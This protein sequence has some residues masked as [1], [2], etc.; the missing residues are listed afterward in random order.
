[1]KWLFRKRAS[2]ASVN[3][4]P[5]EQVLLQWAAGTPWTIRDAF[6]GTQ[7]LGSTGSGKTSASL[8]TIV[9]S[10]LRSGFGG[11]FF[12]VK[13]EDRATYERWIE[14][15][16]RRDDLLVFSPTGG[17]RYNFM[18]AELEQT[19][20]VAA[21]AENLTALVMTAAEIGD[22][23]RGSAGGGGENATYFIQNSHKYCRNAV[24]VLR[25]SGNPITP[26]NLL[27]VVMSTP[28]TVDEL[29]SPSWQ[30]SSFCFQCLRRAE[31]A[32]MRESERADLGMAMD[33]FC[34]ELPN[35]NPRT[36][37]SIETTL[38]A[39]LDALGRGLVRDMVSA[40]SSNFSASML[41][42]GAIVIADFPVL[43]YRD[44]GRLIQVMLK[45]SLQRAHSRRDVGANPRPCFMVCDEYQYLAVAEDQPF[46]TIARAFGIAV[47]N[48]TQSI[49]T[50]M[51]ALGPQSEVK[52]NALLGNL[53]T[54]IFHQQTDTRTI[55]YIQE[56][57]G[58]SRQLMVNGNSTRGGDWL[59][60]LFGNN[61][62]GS[63][64]FSE[65]YEF[66]LQARDLNGLAKGGPPHWTAEAI[67]Y[68]GG[69]RFPN[70]RTWMPVTFRQD[71]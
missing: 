71:R 13:P 68:Q 56:L 33:F 28:R 47:V 55:S 22:R 29:N 49:T 69:R 8:K 62:G 53:Q 11:V 46:Q 50:V 52:V 6:Q 2:Q 58:R 36:R 5:L 25:L 37:S 44:I 4:W 48:A 26:Q 34:N 15:A 59:A 30:A 20:D 40:P 21:A 70:G 14:T 17:L 43:V 16:G 31:S 32:S 19:P 35:L 65:A 12:T 51:D 67:V 1:M 39:P 10:M 60:P 41:H 45:A 63:S 54:Q 9:M 18:A 61:S 27:R 24:L 42:N 23:S 57:V 64:G 7:I 38:T 66:E 3:Q